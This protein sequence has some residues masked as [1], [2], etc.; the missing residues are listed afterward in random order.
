MCTLPTYHLVSGDERHLGNELAFVNVGISAAHTAGVDR[1]QAFIIGDIWDWSFGDG[2]LCI[3]SDSHEGRK[4]SK[5]S[6]CIEIMTAGI[7]HLV[8]PCKTARS[9][10]CH[11]SISV[12][13]IL[14]TLR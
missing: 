11:R 7:R 2:E 10:P 6:V 14:Q 4:E 5:E 12:F 1:E 8:V 3:L 13:T 9:F